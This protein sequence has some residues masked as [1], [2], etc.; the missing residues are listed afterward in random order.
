M[1]SQE[2]MIRLDQLRAK[3]LADPVNGLTKEESIEVIRLMRE[4]R[5]A[6][7]Q[8]SDASR[9][10]QAKAAVISGADLLEDLLK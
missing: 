10:K 8:A 3:V 4:G 2:T 5:L 7:Q 1:Y 6:A 9:R